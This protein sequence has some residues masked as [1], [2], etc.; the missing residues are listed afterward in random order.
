MDDLLVDGFV[1]EACAVAAVE[2]DG[3][4]DGVASEAE[5]PAEELEADRDP[6]GCG[7]VPLDRLRDLRRER[8]HHDLVGVE[9]QDPGVRGRVGRGVLLG[10]EAAEGAD[11]DACP[12]GARDTLRPVG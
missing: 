8:R 2:A 6:E 11:E 5:R 4:R 3:R 7:R 10:A 12:R 9:V 1:G